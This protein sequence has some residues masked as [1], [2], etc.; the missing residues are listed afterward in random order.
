MRSLKPGIL[1][2]ASLVALTVLGPAA[3]GA[4]PEKKAQL[5]GKVHVDL[6]D[7]DLTD[8]A[9]AR[10]LLERLKQAAY[11]ACGGDPKLHTAYKTRP[12]QT[13]RVYEECR[14][15]AVKRAI[16]QIG[17]PVL[18][19]VYAEETQRAAAAEGCADEPRSVSAWARARDQSGT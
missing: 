5:I 18:A 14:E 12:E 7:L 3:F 16:D 17:A 4:E 2:T 6:K 9:D 1:A 19:R 11:D 13:V 10:T 15:N 8:A